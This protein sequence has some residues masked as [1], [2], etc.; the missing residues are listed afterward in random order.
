MPTTTKPVAYD[1]ETPDWGKTAPI[2]LNGMAWYPST[3]I[4]DSIVYTWGSAWT[5]ITGKE[6]RMPF[7][8]PAPCRHREEA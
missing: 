5:T 1:T 4:Q 8:S 7:W 6:F 3:K 2:L